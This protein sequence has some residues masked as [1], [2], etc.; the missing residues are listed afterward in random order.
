MRQIAKNLSLLGMVGVLGCAPASDKGGGSA[1]SPA[2]SVTASAAP[3]ALKFSPENS[4][5]EFVG[6][7]PDG[8]HDG[9]FKQFKGIVELNKDDLAKSKIAVDIDTKSLWA[10]N[11]KLTD[12]LKSGD[13]F[14]VNKFD[15][16]TF[17]STG[18]AP[19]SEAGATHA[20]TGDLTL[21][22]VKKSVTFPA[23][24]ELTDDAF[25]LD[26]KFKI[27]RKDFGVGAKTP[28]DEVVAIAVTV[29]APRK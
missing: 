14:E 7:K 26:G 1:T 28:P 25:A 20:I 23:K 16:A 3:G 15:T 5:I 29:K 24:L 21:H 9:G 13:F 27:N 8:K 12:H 22:G 18:I 4:K 19:S 6:T 11:P 2:S 10:D 17:V